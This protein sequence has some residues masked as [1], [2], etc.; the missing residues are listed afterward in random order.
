MS[1]KLPPLSSESLSRENLVFIVFEAVVI[2]PFAGDLATQSSNACTA[3][4]PTP[5]TLARSRRGE[6]Y[7]Q[8]VGK[9]CN[10]LG[11]QGAEIDRAGIRVGHSG[12]SLPHCSYPLPRQGNRWNFHRSETDHM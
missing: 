2:E 3:G 12:T 7:N 4:R 8:G 5:V 9:L 6:G 1:E 11:L 10:H